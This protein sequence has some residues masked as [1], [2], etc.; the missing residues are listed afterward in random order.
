[1]SNV[2][3]QKVLLPRTEKRS[4]SLEQ[5]R[6]RLPLQEISHLPDTKYICTTIRKKAAVLCA[7]RS[8]RSGFLR[9]FLTRKWIL[10]LIS[11]SKHTSNNLFRALKKFSQ[12]ITMPCSWEPVH[13]GART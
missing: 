4:R 12:K 11:A 9:Q 10:F 6:P 2:L 1:M 8:P 13:R 5:V 3:C 7:A